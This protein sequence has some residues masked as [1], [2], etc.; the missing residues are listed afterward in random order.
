MVESNQKMDIL[1]NIIEAFS[2]AKTLIIA[3]KKM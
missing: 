3:C 2:Y 1:S